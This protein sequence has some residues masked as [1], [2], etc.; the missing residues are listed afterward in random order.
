MTHRWLGNLPNYLLWEVI[1]HVFSKMYSISHFW[2][3][4]RVSR[5]VLKIQSYGFREPLLLFR[6]G[7]SGQVRK[8]KSL[9]W[10]NWT[11]SHFFYY[12]YSF[13]FLYLE[14]S[15]YNPLISLWVVYKYITHLNLFNK[16]KVN[17]FIYLFYRNCWIK[18]CP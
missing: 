10:N 12:T 14:L 16:S 13:L 18:N 15:S 6:K 17:K 8:G 3:H 7:L 4:A 2:C 9:L 5:L 11:K 1:H